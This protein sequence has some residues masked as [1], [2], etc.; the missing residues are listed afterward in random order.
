MPGSLNIDKTLTAIG[1]L[2]AEGV[3]WETIESIVSSGTGLFRLGVRDSRW[4][5]DEALDATGFS[6]SENINW[7]N[8]EED[9]LGI[10]YL[11]D[12][13]GQYIYTPTGYRIVLPT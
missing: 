7:E 13:T 3:D 9:F 11:E 12:P 6:G 2:G 10:L 4:V 5:V 1:F 8:Y